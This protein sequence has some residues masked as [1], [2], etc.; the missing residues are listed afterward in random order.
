LLIARAYNGLG[1]AAQK[2]KNTA[3]HKAYNDSTV[4]Y[5]TQSEKLPVNIIFTEFTTGDTKSSLGGT[6]ENRTDA[7]K[8]YTL[9]FEF[10]DKSGNV[11]GTKE[12][13]VASVAPK[14]KGRFSTS[15]EGQNIAAFRYASP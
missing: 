6:I 10:L 12:V 3:Q 13:A 8:S 4:K 11:V 7:E 15:V 2:A 14:A 5:Y 9:R 1:K